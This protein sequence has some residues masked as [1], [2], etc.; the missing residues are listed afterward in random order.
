MPDPWEPD[1]PAFARH[2][3]RSL[4]LELEPGAPLAPSTSLYDEWGLDSLQ[5]FEAIVV[6]ESMA[7]ALVPPPFLPELFTVGDAF[8]YYRMLRDGTFD[9]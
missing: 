9:L 2:L 3:A 8:A 5:A 7:E 4:R 1:G 6:I